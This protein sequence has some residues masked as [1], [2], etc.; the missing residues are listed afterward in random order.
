MVLPLIKPT[1][2]LFSMPLPIICI[3]IYRLYFRW[4]SSYGIR[5]QRHAVLQ[6]LYDFSVSR[7]QKRKKKK[8]CN[9][10]SNFSSKAQIATEGLHPTRFLPSLWTKLITVGVLIEK[11]TKGE[12]YGFK[13]LY[14]QSGYSPYDSR[15]LLSQR[16][17]LTLHSV[18]LNV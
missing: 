10:S 2:R 18:M 6:F 8:Q 13:Q 14:F 1:H 17:R 15:S 12:E 7:D 11:K 4:T 3:Y 16:R 5:L 9:C